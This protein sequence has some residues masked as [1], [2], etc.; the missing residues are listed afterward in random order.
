VEAVL[1]DETKAAAARIDGLLAEPE[2]NIRFNPGPGDWALVFQVNFHVEN[3]ADQY[4]VQSDLRKLL[5][6]RLMRE[7][8]SMPYPT[9]TV[10][11]EDVRPARGEEASETTSESEKRSGSV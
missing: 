3:F 6:K 2:P 8:I 5:Y 1:L 11:L 9:K 10:R 7:K 4:R